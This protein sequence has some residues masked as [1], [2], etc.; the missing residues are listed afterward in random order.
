M[1]NDTHP[2]LASIMTVC[3]SSDDVDVG[4]DIALSAVLD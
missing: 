3:N 4:I 2:L 1:P